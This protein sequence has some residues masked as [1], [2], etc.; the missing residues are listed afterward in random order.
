MYVCTYYYLN[1]NGMR[2]VHIAAMFGHLDALQY[3]AALPGV[4]VA[5]RDLGVRETQHGCGL[6]CDF[7]LSLAPLSSLLG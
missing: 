5:A 1:Q 7:M 3:L 4:D 6:P 2:P